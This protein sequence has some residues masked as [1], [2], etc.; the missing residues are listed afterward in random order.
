[1]TQVLA[2]TAVFLL[3]VI[4]TKINQKYLGN[5]FV[6]NQLTFFGIFDRIVT[7]PNIAKKEKG[8]KTWKKQRK[9]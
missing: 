9:Y 4:F 2:Y 3:F 8:R 1:M 5:I 7:L 6:E